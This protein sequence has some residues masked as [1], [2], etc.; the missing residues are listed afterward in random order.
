[1]P[2]LIIVKDRGVHGEH[3][4]PET[5]GNLFQVGKAPELCF[6]YSSRRRRLVYK[7]PTALWVILGW[8][9]TSAE[10]TIKVWVPN[11]LRLLFSVRKG[12]QLL[13]L[14]PVLLLYYGV[15]NACGR[16]TPKYLASMKERK[17]WTLE[18]KLSALVL[19]WWE[20]LIYNLESGFQHEMWYICPESVGNIWDLEKTLCLMFAGNKVE[21][22]KG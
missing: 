5:Y 18:E 13:K 14:L 11:I 17:H 3:L 12:I 15:D 7:P 8:F 1:M 16:Y 9:K 6:N 2:V 19:K 4:A 20:N 21:R 10:I 22:T